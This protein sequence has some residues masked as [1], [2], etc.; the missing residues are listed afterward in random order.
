MFVNFSLHHL[1]LHN[2]EVLLLVKHSILIEE[3]KIVVPLIFILFSN[4]SIQLEKGYSVALI[5]KQLTSGHGKTLNLY[6]GFSTLLFLII[7]TLVIY[8][9]LFHLYLGILSARPS[10]S[11][12]CSLGGLWPSHHYARYELLA[13][14]LCI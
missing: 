1:L 11:H 2:I 13:K 9:T 10:S 5:S 12:Y 7:G 6:E 4:W 8:Y 3:Q 14:P